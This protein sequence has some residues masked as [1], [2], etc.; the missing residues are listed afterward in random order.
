MRPGLTKRV[1]RRSR[2]TA[3]VQPSLCPQ[4]P[5][6][7]GYATVTMLDVAVI[8]AFIML[9]NC[10][11]AVPEY[12]GV[13]QDSCRGLLALTG[14]RTRLRAAMVVD[15]HF[16]FARQFT[17]QRCRS[18]RPTRFLESIMS[19]TIWQVPLRLLNGTIGQHICCLIVTTRRLAG[20]SRDEY[21]S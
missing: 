15:E 18:V 4:V 20:Q 5:P 19:G 17:T 10:G 12:V 1:Y 3:R 7:T 21:S 16:L 9:P 13:L 2:Y 6:S 14:P 11:P 8:L